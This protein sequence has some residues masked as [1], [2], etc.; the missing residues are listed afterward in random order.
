MTSVAEIYT[1]VIGVDT[2][3]R[4]HTFTIV[5]AATAAVIANQTFPATQTG[6]TR[7]LAWVHRNSASTRLMVVEGIGSYGA[8]LTA[9]AASQGVE[10]V[11]PDPI[12]VGVKRGKGKT[13]VLDSVRIA[14]SVLGSD[15]SHL[16]RPRSDGGI[17][18][19]L[20]VLTVAR[21]G[22]TG[23]K[24][25]AVNQ[26]IAL[27]RTTNLGVDASKG[28]TITQIRGIARWLTRDE[29]LCVAVARAQAVYLARRIL[30][31][32]TLIKDNET[33]IRVIIRSGPYSGLLDL[34][35]FGPVTAAAVIV[36]W[37]NPGRAQGEARFAA[38]AGVNPIPVCSGNTTSHRLNR[39]GDRR[40][41][42][43]LT[44]V[45]RVRMLRDEETII[46]TERRTKQGMTKRSI[47]RMLK[48]YLAREVY[49]VL[50]AITVG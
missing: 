48:R 31:L 45:I 30:E 6:L 8:L 18:D 38:L 7:A 9:R 39:G 21:E 43:A 17:R 15:T 32:K 23:E 35:G 5:A 1:H 3:A 37:G 16:R 50:K 42:K 44:V 10:V 4:T 13:D 40:L 36:A 46:Y 33:Q 27:T 20:Q 49:H 25:R 2:H 14:R 11:E 12:P 19:A 24:T 29:P 28:L 26:L 41:N 22:Q 34:F 47:T